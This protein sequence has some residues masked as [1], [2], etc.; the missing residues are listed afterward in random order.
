MEDE[1]QQGAR[2]DLLSEI[3]DVGLMR[4]LLADLHDDL[5]GKIARFKFLF[6][7]GVQLGDYRT[8]LFGGHLTYNG[9]GVVLRNY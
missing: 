4:H 7:P 8:M 6:D 9:V 3:S 5:Q 2:Q 1:I